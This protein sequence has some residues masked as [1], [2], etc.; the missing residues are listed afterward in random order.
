V[1]TGSWRSWRWWFEN[2]E[3]GDITIAQFPNWPI[4]GIG[5]CWL[6]RLNLTDGSTAH[7]VVGWAMRGLWLVWG[8]DEL[9]RGV[10]PWRRLLGA[11]VIVWQTIS[12]VTTFW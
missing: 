3:T 1:A 8:A 9:A 7:D 4:W 10:N 11:T 12:I 5:L 2:Q 6:V